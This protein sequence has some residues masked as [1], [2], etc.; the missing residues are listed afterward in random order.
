MLATAT[1]ALVLGAHQIGRAPVWIG[2]LPQ[3]YYAVG[4]LDVDAQRG[5]LRAGARR[6]PNESTIT[7][8]DING[9]SE[10]RRRDW[11]SR[12]RLNPLSSFPVQQ[13]GCG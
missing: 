6:R 8:A 2:F 4:A 13:T 5:A 12:C 7:D 10:L 3:G 1:P 9:F 11:L